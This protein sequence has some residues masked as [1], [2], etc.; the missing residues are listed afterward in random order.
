MV[1]SIRLFTNC[2]GFS[3]AAGVSRV[4]ALRL[5]RPAGNRRLLQP[6]PRLS[7]LIRKSGPAAMGL[8]LSLAWLPAVSVQAAPRQMQVAQAAAPQA[9]AP[10]ELQKTLADLDAA[11]SQRD[12]PAVMKFYGTNFK[13]ADGLSRQAFEESL[14]KLW[15][16]YQ[17]LIYKT[18]INSWKATSDGFIAQITTTVTGTEKTADRTLSLKSTLKAE[19]TLVGQTIVSQNILSENSQVT[20]GEAPPTVQLSLPTEVK[21][22]QDYNLDVVVKEPLQDSLLVGTATDTAVTPEAYLKSPR[23]ELELLSAGGIF[24]LGKAPAQPGDRWISIALIRDSG[25]TLITQRLKVIK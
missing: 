7:S 20:S 2:L 6:Q 16:D 17:T 11:A 21:V 3:R 25:M 14:K 12:L 19:Q 8:L 22:G 24:K 18:E 1:Q 4:G 9:A 15:Q 13:T 10:A 23:L 5:C